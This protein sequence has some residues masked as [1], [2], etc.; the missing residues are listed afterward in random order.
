[1]QIDSKVMR[2]AINTPQREC[3]TLSRA[4]PSGDRTLLCGYEVSVVE[5]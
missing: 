1:M 5:Q 3:S 4:P 2:I